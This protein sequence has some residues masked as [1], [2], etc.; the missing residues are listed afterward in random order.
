MQ[1]FNFTV[2]LILSWLYRKG[3]APGRVFASYLFLYG[4]GRFLLEFTRGDEVRGL[5]F[6]GLVSTSQLITAA[7]IFIG[8]AMQ[9]WIGRRQVR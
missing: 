7:L 2:F 5:F 6:G 4:V 3:L 8:V 1:P 9:W